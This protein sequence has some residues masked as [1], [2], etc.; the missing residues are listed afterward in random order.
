MWVFLVGISEVSEIP[1]GFHPGEPRLPGGEIQG[2]EG[3]ELPTEKGEKLWT[4]KI[5][6]FV[7]D[8]LM[9]VVFLVEHDL[10][11]WSI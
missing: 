2:T 1:P 8:E 6:S 11:I 3:K 4:E 9:D 10:T 7:G 5:D